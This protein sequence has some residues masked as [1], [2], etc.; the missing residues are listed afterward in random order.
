MNKCSLN[1]LYAAGGLLFFCLLA[2][3]AW[4]APA[5]PLNYETQAIT[6][7]QAAAGQ[8]GPVEVKP[9]NGPL[10]AAQTRAIKAIYAQLKAHEM[11]LKNVVW[12][13]DLKVIR[14]TW[15]NNDNSLVF[16][17]VYKVNHDPV[18]TNSIY[19]DKRQI[20]DIKIMFLDN[21]RYRY[22]HLDRA[23]Q[24]AVIDG[25]VEIKPAGKGWHALPGK[26]VNPLYGE[27]TLNGHLSQAQCAFCHLLVPGVDGRPG[28]VFFPRYQEVSPDDGGAVLHPPLFFR[29]ADFRLI[30]PAKAPVKLPPGLPNPIRFNLVD[31]TNPATKNL[32]SM[33]ARTMFEAP[34]LVEAMA[35]DNHESV[36]ISVDFG[37]AAP[38]FGKDN[39]VCADAMRKRLF[40]RFRNPMLS[41]DSGVIDYEKP[42]YA[43]H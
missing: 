23:T 31:M 18:L 40:V 11:F 27:Y 13:P 43:G 32:Y 7:F 35:R 28:G 6:I 2:A 34:E 22:I 9:K 26:S 15:A 12:R 24:G 30:D 16:K 19:A 10:D 1:N 36:C 14:M 33:Y 20:V 3:R 39:Y 38:L 25:R 17:I 41:S 29:A 42:Y 21:G 8:G 5:P 4:A 37:P